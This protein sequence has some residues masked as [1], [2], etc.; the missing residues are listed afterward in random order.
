[1]ISYHSKRP[2][3]KGS[4][5]TAA[6][7]TSHVNVKTTPSLASSRVCWS[8]PVVQLMGNV[9]NSFFPFAPAQAHLLKHTPVIVQVVFNGIAHFVSSSVE[10]LTIFKVL[11]SMRYQ[12]STK[13]ELHSSRG[14]IPSFS[15]L[16]PLRLA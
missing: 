16:R 12:V 13:T 4:P 2:H 9:G 1:M 7:A 11:C 14:C 6:I 8:T 5:T 3:S 10:T 15:Y